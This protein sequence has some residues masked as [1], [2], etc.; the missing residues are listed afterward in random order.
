MLFLA[1]GGAAA[2]RAAD[3]WVDCD[4][5]SPASAQT[6][7]SETSAAAAFG[8]LAWFPR[9]YSVLYSLHPLPRFFLHLLSLRSWLT[10]FCFQFFT[11]WAYV[12]TL[13]VFLIMHAMRGN[14]VWQKSV[15]EANFEGG[16]P[17]P[18]PQATIYPENKA[19]QVPGTTHPYPPQPSVAVSPTPTGQFPQV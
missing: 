2:E 13:L 9:M 14:Y 1:T 6:V 12:I 8:F 17:P 4:A 10:I 16:L 18:G 5:W 19:G 15:R 7:C 3:F 11:V